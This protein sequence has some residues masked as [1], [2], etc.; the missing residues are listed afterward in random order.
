MSE[1]HGQCLCGSVR[2]R[3]DVEELSAYQCHCSLCRKASGSAYST[4]LMVPERC[5][6]W[7][8]GREKISSYS[9]E[10]GY[11]VDFCSGCGSPIPNRFRDLPLYSVPLG[12][13]ADAPEV[14]I[15]AQIYLGSKA[16][17]EEGDLQGQKYN[18]MPALDKMLDLLQ[19]D[20]QP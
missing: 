6:V 7:I 14:K 17:W 16:E 8:S 12:S 5:F 18:E 3:F 10:N 4:T 19:I 11:R 13:V 2:F 20:L 1:I 15:V 9:K